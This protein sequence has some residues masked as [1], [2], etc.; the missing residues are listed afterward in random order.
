[1]GIAYYIHPR[2][3]EE[4]DDMIRRTPVNVSACFDES[5]VVTMIVLPPKDPDDEDDED[6]ED[7]E[8][9]QDEDEREP[10]VIR[11]PEE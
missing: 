11:E 6:E 8:D 10:A 3:S 2:K 9:E 1:L 5:L 4:V 7:E